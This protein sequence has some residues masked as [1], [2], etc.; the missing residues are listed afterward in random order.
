MSWIVLAASAAVSWGLY[1]ASLHKGQTEL[2]NPMRAMLC[3]GIAYFLIAVLVPAVAL[4]SQS[5]W[6]NFNF[7]GTATA[8]IAG[9]LGALGAVCITY[10]FRAGGS[11]LIVMP[12]VFGGAPLINVLSTMIVHPPRNP[13]HPLLYVGFLLAASGA[14]MVL[15]Y[16]PQG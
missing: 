11:P 2:G 14:G 6:R 4:T 8:T 9:A 5:E 15:Y 7:S 16:R 1:G 12:L 3:V 13:P 10:A